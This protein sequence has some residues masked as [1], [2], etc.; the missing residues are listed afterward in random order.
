MRLSQLCYANKCIL[1]KTVRQQNKN[2]NQDHR[3]VATLSTKPYEVLY[4]IHYNYRSIRL[5][6]VK[7]I[8]ENLRGLIA[9]TEM[10]F[11][12]KAQ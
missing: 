1:K 10:L 2:K 6:T 8:F 5:I 7:N 3:N 11:L 4:E 12:K 9:F